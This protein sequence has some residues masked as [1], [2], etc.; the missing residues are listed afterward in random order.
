[1]NRSPF[2]RP[3]ARV[4]L[5]MV[6][7]GLFFYALVTVWVGWDTGYRDWA[8]L[9]N[10]CWPSH[11]M[12]LIGV[13]L[14][15]GLARMIAGNPRSQPSYARWLGTTPWRPGQRLPLGPLVWAWEDVVALVPLALLARYDVGL[16]WFVPV[17]PYVVARAIGAALSAAKSGRADAAAVVAF[18]APVLLLAWRWDGAM[19][20]ALVALAAADSLAVRAALS[21]FPWEPADPAIGPRRWPIGTIAWPTNMVGPVSVS[22][23]VPLGW[24]IA[25]PLLAGWWAWSLVHAAFWLPGWQNGPDWHAFM[26]F[27]GGLLVLVRL[28][29]YCGRFHPPINLRGRLFTGRLLIPG[30]D[31]VLL[32][33]A[34]AI[35]ATLLVPGWVQAAGGTPALALAA[36]LVVVSGILLLGAPTLRGWQLTGHHRIFRGTKPVVRQQ[37]RQP[38]SLNGP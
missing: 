38:L 18:V 29:V 6:G 22:E 21:N 33:P 35:A 17:V 28:A 23:P 34:V 2:R 3:L 14:A 9:R 27:V 31:R 4:P 26:T 30:Y 32:T 25:L 15:G 10:A 1:M 19:V 16:P 5:T 7:A 20:A 8:A 36:E 11:V 24:C 12:M 13:P 37:G